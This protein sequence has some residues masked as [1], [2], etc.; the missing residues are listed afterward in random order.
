VDDFFG[1]VDTP[2]KR[3]K[4][5]RGVYPGFQKKFSFGSSD[6]E[7]GELFKVKEE[8]D[9]LLKTLK[10][11]TEEMTDLAEEKQHFKF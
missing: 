5:E 1:Q 8:R 2:K 10:K 3:F 4:S 7:Q 6:D 9:N 11:M